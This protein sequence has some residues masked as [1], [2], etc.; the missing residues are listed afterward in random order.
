MIVNMNNLENLVK[1]SGNSRCIVDFSCLQDEFITKCYQIGEQTLVFECLS[2]NVYCLYHF[3][4]CCEYVYISDI[5]GD[6]TDLSGKTLRAEVAT[7]SLKD[8]CGMWTFYKIDTLN[9]GRR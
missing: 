4:D 8:E 3:E 2:G 9:C 1:E 6:L 7:G 5:C